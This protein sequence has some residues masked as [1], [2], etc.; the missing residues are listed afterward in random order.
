MSSFPAIPVKKLS[1]CR[2]FSNYLRFFQQQAQRFYK[3]AKFFRKDAEK[4]KSAY[5]TLR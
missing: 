5:F 4:Q 3:N 2:N 1:I